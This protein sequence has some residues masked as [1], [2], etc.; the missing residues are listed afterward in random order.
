ML[1]VRRVRGRRPI[2]ATMASG[3]RRRLGLVQETSVSGRRC[4]L[5]HR[6]MPDTPFD[7]DT[8]GR[9]GDL[10]R[11]A[12]HPVRLF[13]RRGE[14]P[15]HLEQALAAAAGAVERGTGG[16][17]PFV[18]A[19][20]TADAPEG[21]AVCIG[22]RDVARYL[23]RPAGPEAAPF[24]E[25]LFALAS[26]SPL[27]STAAVRQRR[28]EVYV[29]AACPNCPH[30]AAAATAL[31]AADDAIVAE[32]V[33][34][35]LFPDRAAAYA[36]RSVPTIVVDGGLTLVGAVR[37]DRLEAEL[38]RL[39]HADGGVAVFRSLVDAGRFDAA[40]A[41]LRADGGCHAF[42]TVWNESAMQ[43]RIGLLL[44]AESALDL[45]DRCLDA[46]VALVAPALESGDAARR[47]DT[48]DLMGRIG[49]PAALPLLET[50]VADDDPDVA[51]AVADAVA[52]LRG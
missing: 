18:D 27:P 24:V 2:A 38:R 3:P 35:E 32:I 30:S 11:T 41:W 20:A 31:A 37:R 22:E 43:A 1:P 39:D 26:S 4:P 48:A 33:D 25:L 23:A 19:P 34:V 13:L 17:V 51:E 40:A 9:L 36:V 16:A 47:G 15:E 50:C 21:L 52:V 44:A 12:A 46:L 6:G 42:A 5:Y 14:L 49:S 45:D 29:A 28:V 7:T 10:A 8:L